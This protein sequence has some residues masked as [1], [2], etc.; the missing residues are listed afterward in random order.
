MARPGEPANA[1]RIFQ[2]SQSRSDRRR[3]YRGSRGIRS[4]SF[5]HVPLRDPD[6]IAYRHEVM[7]DLEQAGLFDSIKAFAGAMRRVRERLAEADQLHHLLQKQRS[8]F[9]AGYGYCNAVVRLAEDLAAASPGSRGLRAF[10]D[11]SRAITTRSNS[12]HYGGAQ[13]NWLA[14]SRRSIT[15]S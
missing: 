11:I 3:D 12:H 5:L 6:A 4:E 9:E 14:R 8:L 15:R 13:R 1:P 7:R 10:Q 2:G